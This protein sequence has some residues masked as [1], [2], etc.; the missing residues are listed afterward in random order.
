MVAKD[1]TFP[2]QTNIDLFAKQSGPLVQS[3]QRIDFWTSLNTTSG[4]KFF[5]GPCNSPSTGAVRIKMYL[6]HGATSVGALGI[7][8]QGAT[9]FTTDPW[10]NT[11]DDQT[12]TATM[13]DQILKAA[14]NSTILTPSDKSLTGASMVAA[15]SFAQGSHFVGTAIMGEINDGSAV[16]DTNT[17]VF[18]TD[19]IFVV[20][21][22]IH[23]DLP[24]GNTQAMVMVV[25]EHAVAKIIALGA[26]TA[27]NSTT[28]PTSSAAPFA[29]TTVPQTGAVIPLVSAVATPVPVAD[30]DDC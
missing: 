21:A 6:T 2:S 25:A 15:K 12:A 5:Q 9:V 4:T 8:A 24:T 11:E 27:S 30:D 29:N 23:P 7:N 16:V 22:S 19:N 3:G 20:D 1:F 17:K 10:M 14:K 28:S 18:G 13:I 26:S